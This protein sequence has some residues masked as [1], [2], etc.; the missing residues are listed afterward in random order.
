MKDKLF[1]ALIYG[2]SLSRNFEKNRLSRIEFG[3]DSDSVQKYN[4]KNIAVD[5]A[6]SCIKSAQLLGKDVFSELVPFSVYGI[7]LTPIYNYMPDE[8]FM[9][10]DNKKRPIN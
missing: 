5:Y 7:L 6:R 3:Y 10:D 1:N 2:K 4:F 8:T 9:Y